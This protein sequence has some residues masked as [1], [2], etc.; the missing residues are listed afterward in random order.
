MTDPLIFR[1]QGPPRYPYQIAALKKVVQTR[2]VCALLMDP[3]MG[4]TAVALDYLSMLA[5][6]IGHDESRA[7]RALICSP[8]AAVDTWVTQ[9][10]TFV[11][12]NISL[13]AEVPGGS[14]KQKAE[15][16]ANR[17]AFRWVHSERREP[18]KR[19]YADAE[20]RILNADLSKMLFSRGSRNTSPALIIESINLESLSSRASVGSRTMAD[21]MFD[22]IQRFAP[23]VIIVDE[24]HKIKSVSS[25]VSRLLGRLSSAAPRRLILTGTPMPKGPIDIW[26]QWRFLQPYAFGRL[27]DDGWREKSRYQDFKNR[28]CILGG[29]FGRQIIGYKNLEEL[30][31]IMAENAVVVKKEEAVGLPPLTQV[32][33]PFSLSPR[34]ERAYSDMA[35]KAVALMDEEKVGAA[36]R[37]IQ[38]LR[39]R[40]I[41]AGFIT[42]PE[43]PTVDVGKSKMETISSLVHDTLAGENRVVVFGVFTHEIE[44]L[45][46]TLAKT[47]T[48]ILV[49]TGATP[50][51]TRLEYRRIFG[52]TKT[53]PQRIVLI[54]QISTISLSVNELVSASHVVFSSLSQRRDELIQAQDRL[55]RIGQ[56]LPVTA[57]FPLAV[58]SIDETIFKSHLSGTRLE[59]SVMNHIRERNGLKSVADH[60]RIES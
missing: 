45:K 23:D 30:H 15:T 25:N 52:D 53:Y 54:A 6:K 4:K 38:I 57:W 43:Q 60:S 37:L 21:L 7:V 20:K 1:P 58:D 40:Q 17:G 33:V 32:P 39:L 5:L 18:R 12:E 10:Q 59:A 16:L 56:K 51:A 34:E 3:G 46:A 27:S 24:S 29:D 47:G 42:H 19:D 2:G 9:A 26:A 28:Y 55:H 22:R 8:K 11:P 31:E 35:K 36:N 41:T 49:I 44:R 48:E 13:W 50:D 14:I